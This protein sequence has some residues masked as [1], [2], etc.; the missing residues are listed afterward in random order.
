MAAAVAQPLTLE[1]RWAQALYKATMETFVLRITLKD[2][3]KEAFGRFTTDN[4]NYRVEIRIDGRLVITPFIREPVMDGV[5]EVMGPTAA[6]ARALAKRL[7]REGAT[8]EFKT[9][10][11]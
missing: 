5:I 8:V 4:V 6:E 10:L 9:V 1:V 7:S 2:E 11:N 3:A